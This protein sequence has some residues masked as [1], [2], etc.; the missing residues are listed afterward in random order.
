MSR[1][2]VTLHPRLK[3]LTPPPWLGLSRAPVARHVPWHKRRRHE[4]R[5]RAA[6][7]FWIGCG[8]V[9][10]AIEA[11]AAGAMDQRVVRSL[12]ALFLGPVY[13]V[14]RLLGKSL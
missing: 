7:L 14:M 3:S 12:A 2:T 9:A 8:L 11:Q 1:T 6:L 5:R 13:L 4:H 10:A